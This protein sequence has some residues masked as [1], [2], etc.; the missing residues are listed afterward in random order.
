M[1]VIW[2]VFVAVIRRVGSLIAPKL[3]LQHKI[4]SK[5]TRTE[6][7]P[8]VT[9][10]FT[11]EF[12]VFHESSFNQLMMVYNRHYN[13]GQA[14]VE[15]NAFSIEKSQAHCPLYK[16]KILKCAS[17]WCRSWMSTVIQL[18]ARLD[19]SVGAY[20]LSSQVLVRPW[21]IPRFLNRYL[22]VRL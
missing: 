20:P 13:H 2:F 18:Q 15:Q 4:N 22:L 21:L 19:S 17:C 14:S 8:K 5:E 6:G 7:I 11:S 9:P 3:P 16:D 12:S 10:T 1:S